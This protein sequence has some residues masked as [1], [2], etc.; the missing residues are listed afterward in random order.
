MIRVATF[1]QK[2]VYRVRQ[3]ALEV[4]HVPEMRNSLF[5]VLPLLFGAGVAAA[6]IQVNKTGGVQIDVPHAWKVQHAEGDVIVATD[7]DEHAAIMLVASEASDMKKVGDLVD[8]ELAKVAKDMKWGPQHETTINGMKGVSMEGTAKIDGHPVKT[9]AI[10]VAT[11][12]KKGVFLLGFV[13]TDKEKLYEHDMD[14][15]AHSLK[16]TK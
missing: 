15:I 6:D 13:E 3:T 12:K 14:A 9:G 11:S 5:L 16:Q 4:W 7:K 10:I 2:T 1:T 8:Q